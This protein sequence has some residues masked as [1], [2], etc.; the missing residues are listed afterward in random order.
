MTD[1][2]NRADTA[3]GSIDCLPDF[4]GGKPLKVHHRI[5]ATAADQRASQ[6]HSSTPNGR[7]YSPAVLGGGLADCCAERRSPL[8]TVNGVRSSCEAFIGRV[9]AGLFLLGQSAREVSNEATRTHTYRL[10]V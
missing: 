2:S 9:R 7:T 1:W 6:G 3:L 4:G 8:T 10:S 5:H